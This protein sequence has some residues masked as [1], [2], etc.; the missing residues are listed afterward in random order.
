MRLPP[1]TLI[2]YIF[3][4][5][6]SKRPNLG[7]RCKDFMLLRRL[8]CVLVL[9]GAPLPLYSETPNPKFLNTH[10]VFEENRGQASSPVR[11]LSRGNGH[12]FL[13]LDT[14]AVL[15]FAD[16]SLKVRMK[17]I[18]QN[19]QSRIEG[20]G[21]QRSVTNYFSG[22]DSAQWI[23]GVPHFARV[24]YKEVYAGIDVV[25]YGSE[26]ELEYDF[27]VKPFADPST[28]SIEFQGTQNVGISP[29]GDLVLNT[30][31]GEIRHRRPVAYQLRDNSKQP[32]EARFVLYDG[33]VGFELG[34]Y[35]RALPLTIDPTL[36]WSSYL[37]GT[38]DDQGNDVTVDSSG[39][40]YIVGYTQ[41]VTPTDGTEPPPVITLQPE[42][43]KSF[44]AFI[45]KL[46]PSGAILFKT[47]FGGT[48]V[49][50]AH[51][52]ALDAVGNIYVTGYT[53]STDFPTVNP[54]QAN[55][56]GVQDAYVLKMNSSGDVIQFA[57][58]LGGSRSD[59]GYGIDVDGFGNAFIVG[60]TT[61]N[62]N[63][64]V[65][66]N[67]FQ[68]RFGGGLGDAFIT[69][70]TPANTVGFSTYFGG[71][72]WD[73]SYDVELDSEGNIVLVGFTTSGFPTTS[74]AL[75]RTFR[76]GSYD[77]FVAKMNNAGTSLV[78]STYFGGNGDDEVVRL[79]LDQNNNIH[80]TG[81]TTSQDFPLKN[82]AQ[83]FQAGA[84]DAFVVKLHSDGQ[85]ADFSTYIGGEDTEGG[86]SI[87]VDNAGFV[88]VAGFTNSI[89]FYA[90]NAIGGFLRGL[91]D[92]FLL[93]IAPDA[94]FVVYSTYIGGF[95]LEGATAVAVDSA[96][97][98]YVTGYTSSTDFPVVTNAFQ[99]AK[100][101]SQDAFIIK[102][103]ADDVKASEG[104]SFPAGGGVRTATAGQTSA[105]IFGYVAVDVA[106]GAAPSG[107][108]IIDLR[109]QGTLIN[110]VTIPMPPLGLVGRLYVAT[111]VAGS[112]AVTMVNPNNEDTRVDF[113]FTPKGGE[114]N[115]FG[116]FTLPAHVQTAG[117][118][119]GP[120]WN[121][122]TDLVGTLTYT[123]EKPVSAIGLLVSTGSSPANVYQ[124]IINPYSANTQQVVIPQ[125]VDG[126][127][128]TT[129]FYLIN[130]TENTITGEIRLF[131]SIDAASPGVPADLSTDLGVA[132]VFSYSIEPRGVFTLS[133][134]GETGD[135]GVG[136]AMVVPT[137]GSNAPLAYDTISFTGTGTGIM[138]TTIEGVNAGSN[139]KAYVETSGKYPDD[140]LAAT[141]AIA[142]ANSSD[143][144]ATVALSLIGF[145]GTNSGLTATLTIPPKGHVSRF[146][147]TIP[148]FENLPSPYA[149][150][151]RVTTSQPGVAFAG[152][153]A[154][155]NEQR[156][157]L[158]TATGPLKDVTVSPGVP[159][160]PN[161][162]IFPH[163]VD[164]GGYATQ[165]I[166]INGASG[167]AAAGTIRYLNP[168]GNPLNIA[169]AP[170]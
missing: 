91:R 88:Y 143:S 71:I 132:S 2:S 124:P 157:F 93:K 16:P 72:G 50:E 104:Y 146:L 75:Y 94:S 87:A 52:V 26:R 155:Y 167:G 102:V 69:K 54:F 1:A 107:L 34:S 159:N 145:D 96:G 134:R 58:Y 14:E 150:V 130:P 142:L 70:I 125:F 39:N 86:V 118:L 15:T 30:S 66:S 56:A 170:E 46:D 33:R 168:S 60:D 141:S 17:L 112:T 64:P 156:Q 136:F 149:G 131:K 126:L 81:Y 73:R 158:V 97:N 5:H 122:P 127:G 108:E 101:G 40:V 166:V 19:S 25:Y 129:S 109:A 55:M 139:F 28:I 84:F 89:Q 138:T 79:A 53:T 128:W 90:I 147:A 99:P 92:G 18:G 59:R 31:G 65:T 67:A 13:L 51:S 121:L 20:V 8:L 4:F 164:G 100:A 111:S 163:L 11:F 47:Y 37:G 162:V 36:V 153:R 38:G 113:Y 105:P 169:I 140:D 35:D 10:L 27:E 32:V 119:N 29:E 106:S 161:P 85:D 76:G 78:F 61:S 43:G 117:F 120:P 74:N 160:A 116:N 42:E 41:T 62:T 82:P 95:G 144:P 12:S 80:F 114:T 135:L 77:G 68:S 98:A 49:D 22:N 103:N 57:S 24:R 154:R 44:E 165:I 148:G 3:Q 137:D 63:F 9:L 151:L 7:G 6:R 115:L 83:I 152:F 48:G 110:E 23:T 45:T 133:S 123:A 21:P